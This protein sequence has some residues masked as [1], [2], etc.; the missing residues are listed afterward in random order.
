MKLSEF[1]FKFLSIVILTFAAINLAS[2]VLSVANL[3]CSITG[4]CVEHQVMEN[5]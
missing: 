3:M 1:T 5:M 4:V 2:L